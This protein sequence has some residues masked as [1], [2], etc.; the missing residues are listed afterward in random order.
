M[1][2]TRGSGCVSKPDKHDSM[3]T[4][5]RIA[6]AAGAGK[7]SSAI[8]T[9]LEW[10]ADRVERIARKHG[11]ELPDNP[12]PAKA[13][14]QALTPAEEAPLRRKRCRYGKM[15]K[16]HPRTEYVTVAISKAGYD[17]LAA[18]AAPRRKALSATAAVAID[19]ALRH[20]LFADMVDTA[21]AEIEG[22]EP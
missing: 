3:D 9:M 6:A 8:G 5:S 20:G 22:T 15:L 2:N 19:H 7:G 11:I 14:V 4:I 16:D 12:Q 21:I 13:S 18:I 1:P 10:P 17:A